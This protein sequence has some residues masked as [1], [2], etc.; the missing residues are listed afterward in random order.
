MLQILQSFK[1]CITYQE[2][3]RNV[4]LPIHLISTNT[5]D[6]IKM[7]KYVGLLFHLQHPV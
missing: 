5:Y 1:G 3:Q 7:S 2:K 4:M 6:A